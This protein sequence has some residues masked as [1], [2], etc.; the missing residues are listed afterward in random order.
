[1]SATPTLWHY[2]FGQHYQRILAEKAIRPSSA[3]I[4]PAK[5]PVVWFSRNR[6]WEPAAMRS[7]ITEDG[8]LKP[9]T[10]EELGQQAGGLFRIGVAKETAPHNWDDFVRLSGLPKDVIIGLRKVAKSRV[11]N[12]KDWFASFEPVD[13]SK[14]LLVEVWQNKAWTHGGPG[15]AKDII[16]ST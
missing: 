13:Q 8:D 16:V 11:A 2:T 4:E 14:W 9:L 7:L 6:I 10:M 15:S 3:Y 5:F 1:M 12:L